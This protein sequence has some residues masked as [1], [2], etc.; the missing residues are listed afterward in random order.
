MACGLSRRTTL[1]YCRPQLPDVFDNQMKLSCSNCSSPGS[2]NYF[3]P[4]P[5]LPLYRQQDI[6]ECGN[7]R[8]FGK[9][10]GI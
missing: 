3:E 1:G 9:D 6:L 4:K 8:D 7:D 10:L 5:Y 2:L